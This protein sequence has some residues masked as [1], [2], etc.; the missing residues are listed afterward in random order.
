ME[1]VPIKTILHPWEETRCHITAILARSPSTPLLTLT[2]P[3]VWLTRPEFMIRRIPTKATRTWARTVSHRKHVTAPVMS[4][5]SD[6]L[7]I[8]TVVGDGD[9]YSL[10]SPDAV[11]DVPSDLRTEAEVALEMY[12]R[13][14]S[15]K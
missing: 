1:L 13:H 8:G 12:L 15:G 10:A 7:A 5:L 6:L 4:V 14:V 3:F 2:G 11:Q 9:G